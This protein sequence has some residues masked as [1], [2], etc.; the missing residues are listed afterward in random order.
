[1]KFK[2]I[3]QQDIPAIFEVRV[4]TDENNFTYE[5]L[6]TRGIS[7]ETIAEKLKTSYKGWLCEVEN[8]V[9][10]F[11]IADKLTTAIYMLAVL[12]THKNKQ[13]ETRLLNLAE[14]WLL[15]SGKQSLRNTGT[16]RKNPTSLPFC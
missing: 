5:E 15:S 3:T 13:I 4:A 12:P 11:I 9:V 16:T 6:E 8:E 7:V 1:M 2:E 10:G 14:H